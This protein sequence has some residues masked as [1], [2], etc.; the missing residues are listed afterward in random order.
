M[1]REK[2]IELAV[3]RHLRSETD[4][5]WARIWLSEIRL[6]TIVMQAICRHFQVICRQ[7]QVRHFNDAPIGSGLK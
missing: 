3:R 7:Y 6:P 1:T 5:M 2:A 4:W